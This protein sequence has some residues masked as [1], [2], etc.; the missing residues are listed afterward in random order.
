MPVNKHL[1]YVDLADFSAGVFTDPSSGTH[2]LM[3]NTGAQQFDDAYPQV[4]GG[5][6]SFFTSSSFTTSGLD[7]A[8]QEEC[9]GL[10]IVSGYARRSPPAG[11]S[12]VYYMTTWNNTDGKPRVYRM[13]TTGAQTTWHKLFTGTG[14]A[15]NSSNRRYSSFARFTTTG[16]V[17]YVILVLRSGENATDRGTYTIK[18]NPSGA[19]GSGDDGTV[20]KI[21]THYGP[22]AISQARVIIGGAESGTDDTS[23][24]WSDV[25]DV[26]FSGA[27]H[28]TTIPVPNANRNAVCLIATFDPDQLV[29]GMSGAAWVTITGDINSATTPIR[30]MGDGHYP[31]EIQ[32]Q[33]RTPNGIVFMEQDGSAYITDGRTFQDLTPLI[34][35]FSD[36][37]SNWKGLGTGTFG[38]GFLLLPG[39]LVWNEE[40]K[41]WFKVSDQASILNAF[42]PAAGVLSASAG[43]NFTLRLRDIARGT[44]TRTSSWTWRSAPFAQP[45]G[46][47]TEVREV[48]IQSEVYSPSTF[49]ITITDHLGNT[50][51]IATPTQPTGKHAVTTA[52]LLRGDYCDVKIAA[53]ANNGTSEAPTVERVRLGFGMGHSL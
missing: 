43:V 12:K 38:E 18:Y 23:I 24:Y 25:G 40:S 10:F 20:A 34:A 48:V 52:T 36:V 53:A 22:L 28:G 46:T 29:I 37:A 39:A 30:S 47:Q 49:T 31:R 5:I 6:R 42:D 14:V 21:S 13:D 50:Q 35:P 7:N 8:G 15:D 3:P 44:G 32:D 11:D 9:T 19:S 33:I 45:D 4:G 17:D 41:G 26:T 16:G 2:L 27:T 51:T 1:R